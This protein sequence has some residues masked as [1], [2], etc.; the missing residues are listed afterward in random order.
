[1]AP[2][3]FVPSRELQSSLESLRYL[4]KWAP[5]KGIVDANDCMMKAGGFALKGG[6][7]WQP[8][9]K[10][11]TEVIRCPVSGEN[12]PDVLRFERTTLC[13]ANVDTLSA[14]LFVGDACA[15]NFANAD[16]PGGRYRS[17]G[18]AQE[19][20]LCRLLPQLYSSLSSSEGYPIAPDTALVTRNLLAVRQPG[21]YELCESRGDCTI[22]SAAMPC[23]MA[24]RRPKGGWAGSAW[25]ETVTT[26]IRSVLN[27]ARMT[28][29]PNLI[30]GAFGCGAFGNP[31]G[32]V[33]AVFREQLL[34]LEFQGAF[35]CIV[36]AII[37]PMG[38]GNLKPFQK[39]LNSIFKDQG[40]NTQ[41]HQDGTENAIVDDGACIDGITP[42]PD[43]ATTHAQGMDTCDPGD[44]FKV[45]ESVS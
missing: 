13:T 3:R 45:I 38:T 5:V 32:P 17:G 27:A 21:T 39:E 23:G 1:M 10:V 9:P 2:H 22:I 15:L 20:D 24:D 11:A 43:S 18:L 30:L 16:I 37:D 14:A 6:T 7:G 42:S 40:R 4:G 35:S 31:A 12:P 33:A 25:A 29:K 8:L 44:G 28:G 19:E 26:R 36:F 34:S 41:L